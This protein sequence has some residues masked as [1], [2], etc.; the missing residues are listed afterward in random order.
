MAPLERFVGIL[1][2]EIISVLLANPNALAVELK[3][4]FEISVDQ[5]AMET[6]AG[7]TVSY[8]G[9][10]NE[11]ASVT[12]Y[13]GPPDQGASLVYDDE[14][15]APDTTTQIWKLAP[16]PS[17]YWIVC[18][19]SNTAAQ[20]AQKVPAGATSCEVVRERNVSFGDGRNPIR[21]AICR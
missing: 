20:V 5:K 12:V 15:T 2:L 3:C 1:A 4:P 6:P 17:S 9:L 10:K 7:W 16:S 21:S 18:G 19:Y 8:N 11:L 14:K 13:E